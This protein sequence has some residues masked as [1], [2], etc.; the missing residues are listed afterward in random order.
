MEQFAYVSSHDLQEPLRMVALFTQ[1]LERRYK[2][3][4]DADADDYINFIVEG[5][6]RMKLLI[7]DLLAY[8]RVNTKG[9]EFELVDLDKVMNTCFTKFKSIFRRC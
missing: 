1:L 7:D 2:G 3:K 8:S 4:L 9:G 6:Q 5:A